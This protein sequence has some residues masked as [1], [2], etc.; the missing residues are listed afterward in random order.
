MTNPAPVALPARATNPTRR[1]QRIL[2]E[3]LPAE[4]DVPSGTPLAVVPA[5][6]DFARGGER[7]LAEAYTRWSPLIY[8]LALRSL[9]DRDE[10]QDVVQRVFVSAWTGRAGFDPARAPLSAWLVGIAR[11]A[12]ADQHDRRSRQR[13]LEDALAA[14]APREEGAHPVDVESRV[15]I[16]DEMARLDPLPRDI[17][18]LAFFDDLSHSQIAA[19]MNLPLG[20]VK[21]HIK[22]SLDRLRARLEVI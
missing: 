6:A 7:A 3:P 14:V 13:R 18:R 16:A 21:S 9:G 11:H 15:L 19:R 22:R 8:T 1:K 17:L 20:T 4:N 10:A 2:T 5:D 12:I